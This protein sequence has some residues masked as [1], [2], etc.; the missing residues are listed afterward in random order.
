MAAYPTENVPRR[1]SF[2][3]APTQPGT[4]GRLGGY[5]I[6]ETI[7]AGGTLQDKLQP[8]NRL[9]LKDIVRIGLQAALGLA[10]AHQRGLI[11][12]DIKPGNLLLE[13]GEQVK[14]TDFGLAHAAEDVPL[15]QTGAVAGTPQ[16]M[17]PEQAEG[18]S[19]DHRSDL[20]SFGAVLYAMCT[21][22]CGSCQWGLIQQESHSSVPS[23]AARPPADR[24]SAAE[25]DKVA[26][27][28]R[29]TAPPR[30][31]WLMASALSV[32]AVFLL[33]AGMI[34]LRTSDGE[35]ILE[36]DDPQIA[37]Q[38]GADGGIVVI[39]RRTDRTYTLRR[40]T[41]RLP[42]GDHELEVTTPDGLQLDTPQFRLRRGDRV[43][44]TV[45]AVKGRH[46]EIVAAQRV[47][48]Q[49]L[50]PA[51]ANLDPAAFGL[52]MHEPAW[53]VTLWQTQRP[54][55]DQ[56][57]GRAEPVVLNGPPDARGPGLSADGREVYV[58]ALSETEPRSMDLWRSVH[59][60]QEVT[61]PAAEPTPK[62]ETPNTSPE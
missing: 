13:D 16:F 28:S 55:P 10:A 58:A 14:I 23:E 40:G 52:T 33:W 21:G 1:L 35:Y 50:A 7:G 48:R 61:A 36:T 29:A 62:P 22:H 39:D 53:R 54:D 43:T 27:P 46:G 59:L 60:S 47:N 42:S 56:P 2:L 37:A 57:F 45:R 51:V 30:R 32:A 34:L 26:T 5:E 17:S 9:E 49:D 41:N 3:D 6:L 38:L 15:T 8:G 18:T 31:R 44:A 19:L 4:L 11:H 24:P 20:F 12:R 25:A